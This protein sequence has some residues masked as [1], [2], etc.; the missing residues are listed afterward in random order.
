MCPCVVS[1]AQ[2]IH[3]GEKELEAKGEEINEG[4]VGNLTSKVHFGGKSP[5]NCSLL[6]SN[7]PLWFSLRQDRYFPSSITWPGPRAA[8]R[9][10]C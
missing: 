8:L 9:F 4:E 2:R 3:L 10:C 1:Y 7:F 6:T 5:Q